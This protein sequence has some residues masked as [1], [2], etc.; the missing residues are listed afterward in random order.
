[1]KIAKRF[2][3]FVFLCIVTLCATTFVYGGAQAESA[4]EIQKN[5]TVSMAGDADTLDPHVTGAR[6]AYTIMMNIFDT[7]VFR[8][9]DSSYKPGLATEW[10]NSADGTVYTFK[11]KQGVKFHDGTAFDADAVVYNLDR[12]VDPAIQSRFAAS[13][14]G[15]YKSSRALD[16]YTVEVTYESPIA[17]SVLLDTL[18]QAYLGMV[19]PTAAE[20]YGVD[21]FGR[22]PVGTGPFVFKEWTA[23]NEV[24]LIRNDDYDW[25]SPV[26][27]HSGPAYLEQIMFI[28]IPEDSTRA[29]TLETGESDIALELGEEA[30]EIFDEDPQFQIVMGEVPGC[31]VILWM[32]TEHP[33]LSDIKVRKAILHA[34]DQDLLARTIFRGRVKPV[35]GPLGPGTW[36]YN[37]AVEKMYPYDLD[38]AAKLLDEAGWKLNASTGIREKDGEP[39]AFDVNDITEKRRIEF[40]QAQMRMVGMDVDARAVTSDVLYQITREADTYSMASTWW[41]YSDPDVLRVLY[42]SSEVGTGFAISRYRDDNLDKMLEDALAELDTARREQRYFEI[43]ELIMD[44]ALTVPVY[45]RLVHDGLKA[46]ITGYRNDRGQYPVL[47]DVQFE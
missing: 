42:H 20:K 38:A 24:T 11:L 14:I 1:M 16:D 5:L 22:N 4:G 41:G 12:V 9:V 23:Q 13:A 35:K 27:K 3:C 47:F 2:R 43:Q 8:D 46:D 44:M 10:S 31:P 36:G 18:S 37:P 39:L 45:A 28:T 40:F 32:N 26:F 21:D 15:P 30:I 33:I 17:P 6:R 7:L 34:F 25:A 29:A 19:S